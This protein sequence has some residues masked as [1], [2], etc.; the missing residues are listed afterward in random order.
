MKKIC[1]TGSLA[2]GKTTASKI[3]S[4]RRGP[5]FNADE[6][7][8]KLYK[9]NY[10]KQLILKKFKIKSN[11]NIKIYFRNKIITNK[12]F[13]NKIEKIIHPIVRKEMRKFTKK[14]IK[15][16]LIFY[17]IPLLIE[18]KMMKNFDKIIFVKAKKN[19]RLKRFKLK[20]GSKKLFEILNNKQ[21][22]DA[23]K[24]K[25]CDHVVVN[26]K[27]LK[28]LKKSLLGIIGKYE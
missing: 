10:F 23:K 7:V 1:I 4:L 17:E 25:F 11:Q 21:L 19:I 26:E 27:N 16:K 8:K 14:N 22:S 2:S 20:G 9:Q 5:L 15:K 28:F 24:I 6:V 12:F 3:L 18:S 13:I